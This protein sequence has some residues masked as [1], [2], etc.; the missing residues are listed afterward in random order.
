MALQMMIS[1]AREAK[2]YHS[3]AT[4][5]FCNWN[6]ILQQILSKNLNDVIM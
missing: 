5:R 2:I 4:Y 6:V 3:I 1:R